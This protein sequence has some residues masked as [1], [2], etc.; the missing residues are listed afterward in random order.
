MRDHDVPSPSDRRIRLLQLVRKLNLRTWLQHVTTYGGAGSSSSANTSTPSLPP[1]ATA[2]AIG[3]FTCAQAS[4]T[5]SS[6]SNRGGNGT[7]L[8]QRQSAQ[9]SHS[10]SNIGHRPAAAPGQKKTFHQK[11]WGTNPAT[12][13]HSKP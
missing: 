11:I 9:H 5:I 12:E 1:P 3:A 8:Q 7:S 13:F 4:L 2:A 6:A 10:Q